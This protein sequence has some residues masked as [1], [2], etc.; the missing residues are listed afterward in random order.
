MT[1]SITRSLTLA[2]LLIALL[3]I[4]FAEAKPK[5]NTKAN[6]PEAIQEK[7]DTKTT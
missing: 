1:V 3:T 6:K 5:T 4:Q 2:L 7:W